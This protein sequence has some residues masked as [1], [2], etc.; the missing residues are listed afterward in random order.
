MSQYEEYW[1]IDDS[2]E[3][4]TNT[5]SLTIHTQESSHQWET[6]FPPIRFSDYEKLLRVT[7]F[8]NR[9]ANNYAEHK[10]TKDGALS[11]EEIDLADNC[12]LNCVPNITYVCS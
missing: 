7:A 3:K 10:D 8:V 4:E 5:I 11:T 6:I 9:F 2:L 12:W 1:L